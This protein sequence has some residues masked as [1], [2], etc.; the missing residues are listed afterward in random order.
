MAETTLPKLRGH[1]GDLK[2][3]RRTRDFVLGQ[4]GSGLGPAAVSVGL[5]GMGGA[6]IAIATI[7]SS[8]TADFVEFTVNGE[9]VRG[10]FW[11]FPF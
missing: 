8:E 2:R 11:R 4:I 5:A 6:G 3:S 7:D 1:I 10:W 9:A